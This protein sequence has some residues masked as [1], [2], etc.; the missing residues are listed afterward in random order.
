MQNQ[1]RSTRP[2]SLRTGVLGHLNQNQ[3]LGTGTTALG[4]LR[5]R[6]WAPGPLAYNQDWGTGITALGP[7]RT[8]AAAPGLPHSEPGPGRWDHNAG[9][10]QNQDRAPGPLTYNQDRGTGTPQNQDRGSRLPYNQDPGT[11][12]T[13][14]GSLRTRPGLQDP[15]LRTGAAGPLRTSAGTGAAAS[16]AQHRLQ[17]RSAT[18]EA[19]LPAPPR[20]F[21][22][23][24]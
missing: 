6:I 3:D 5:T 22:T 4:P 24:Q 2:L 7:L 9:T 20:R 18:T 23:P 1:D 21:R 19:L 17:A 8:R 14:P 15:S 13:T 10:P 12:T 11:G 16:P